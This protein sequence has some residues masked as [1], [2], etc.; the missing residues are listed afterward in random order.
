MAN[1]CTFF[2]LT[3]TPF[4]KSILVKYDIHRHSR[5]VQ[6]ISLAKWWQKIVQIYYRFHSPSKKSTWL[7]V[8][9][10][11]RLWMLL[12]RSYLRDKW[13]KI[14]YSL[15]INDTPSDELQRCISL[16]LRIYI[17][18]NAIQNGCKHTWERSRGLSTVI[19]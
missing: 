10:I 17:H 5:K 14:S 3:C 7:L 1:F 4:V 11:P 6:K 16:Y 15:I 18:M 8:F 2:G 12:A 19:C 13:S 9:R